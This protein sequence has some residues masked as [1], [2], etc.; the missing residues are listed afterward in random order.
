MDSRMVVRNLVANTT[1]TGCWLRSL[2]DDRSNSN[3]GG[4]LLWLIFTL[5]KLSFQVI[6]D[7]ILN[8]MLLSFWGVFGGGEGE[9][10]KGFFLAEINNFTL[11]MTSHTCTCS[12]NNHMQLIW[13]HFHSSKMYD[14]RLLLWIKNKKVIV[15][16]CLCL[17]YFIDIYQYQLIVRVYKRK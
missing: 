11:F 8:F 12:R 5:F 4:P 13:R 10:M 6:K 1:W 2:S 14:K 9:G 16:F 17:L 3:I 7:F 15:K